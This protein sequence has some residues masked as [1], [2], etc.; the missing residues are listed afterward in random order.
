MLNSRS[1]KTQILAC[2]CNA[3]GQIRC[4]HFKK[5]RKRVVF[6]VRDLVIIIDIAGPG[7]DDASE[8]VR[9]LIG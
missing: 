4:Y 2:A 8:N 6:C 5:K 3:K 7:A 1:W 9:P